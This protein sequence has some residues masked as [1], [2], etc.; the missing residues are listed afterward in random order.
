MKFEKLVEEFDWVSVTSHEP[1]KQTKTRFIKIAMACIANHVVDIQI[2]STVPHPGGAAAKDITSDK[3]K[4]K[5]AQLRLQFIK[6]SSYDID[7]VELCHMEY[8]K[9]AELLIPPKDAV[10]ASG[11]VD[12][13]AAAN[14]FMANCKR[15]RLARF[16]NLPLIRYARMGENISSRTTSFA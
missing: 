4:I 3:S 2:L 12:I 8:A 7:K 16:G 14:I 9:M 13:I 1:L 6:E 11:K 10:D 5:P 15:N